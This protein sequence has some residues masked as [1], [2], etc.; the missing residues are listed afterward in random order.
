MSLSSRI[1]AIAGG[2]GSGKTTMAKAL[3]KALE[4][5]LGEGSCGVL[6]Q[7]NYYHDQSKKFDGD[8]G[9][10]NFDHPDALDFLELSINLSSLVS[11]LSASVPCYDFVTHSRLQNRVHFP[12]KKIILLD[13]TM[14]LTQEPIRELLFKSIFLNIPEE[15]RFERRLR[16][17]VKERGRTPEGVT[18]QFL[19]QVKPMHDLFVQPTALFASWEY[20]EKNTME[21]FIEQICPSIIEG[22]D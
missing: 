5:H 17:D 15:V 7:D 16:R 12:P 13:G 10:V 19:H 6:S 4:H 14:V 9:S 3:T 20:S 2:S 1:I 18:R 11:G 21:E 22:I 8:G